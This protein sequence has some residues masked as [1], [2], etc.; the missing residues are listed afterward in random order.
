MQKKLVQLSP[1]SYLYVLWYVY[2][3]PPQTKFGRGVIGITFSVC[4]SV[5]LF[6]QNLCLRNWKFRLQTKIAFVLRVC[7][8]LDLI[9]IEKGERKICLKMNFYLRVETMLTEIIHFSLMH[10]IFM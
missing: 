9:Q 8:Y 6:V 7:H 3:I 4:L 2:Y 10:S 1:A 5:R